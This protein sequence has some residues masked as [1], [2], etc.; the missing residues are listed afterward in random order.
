[1]KVILGIDPGLTHTGY[2]VIRV[3]G[4]RYAPVD[5]GTIDTSPD[6]HAADRLRRLYKEISGVVRK[7]HPQEAGIESV[8]FARNAKTAISVAEAKGVILLSLAE[9]HVPSF[10]YTPLEVKK[11]VAGRGRAEK[12]QVQKMVRM[13]L[14]LRTLPSPDH[15]ADALAIAICHHHYSHR[16]DIGEVNV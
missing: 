4:N 2:G 7:H 8:F 14:G 15:V 12:Q 6:N 10:D 11:A 3:D 9:N 13:I 1:M 16:L 5:Y